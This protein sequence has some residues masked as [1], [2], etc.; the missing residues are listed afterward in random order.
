DTAEWEAVSVV[1]SDMRMPGMDG[2]EFLSRVR[3]AHPLVSRVMLTGNNDQATAGRAVNEGSIFR[4]INKPC[5]H[6]QLVATID[7]AIRQH[8]LVAAEKQILEQTLAGSIQVLTEILALADARLFSRCTS[9]RDRCREVTGL[10]PPGE[11]WQIESAAMLLP[12][13][14]IAIPP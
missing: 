3:D 11:L 9:V 7:D 2:V 1:V 4:F 6:E 13:G 14:S 8:Q 12:I 10:I 5:S